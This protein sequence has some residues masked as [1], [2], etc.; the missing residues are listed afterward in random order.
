MKVLLLAGASSIHTIRWANGLSDAGHEVHLV[1]QHQAID[2]FKSNVVIHQFKN[3]GVIGY[4][5][6]AIPVRRLI[7]KIKPD[8]LNAH[9]ASG[10]GTTARLVN[11]HPWVL[12]VWGTD[13]YDFPY[14]S[15][16]H[17]WL[18]RK[19]LRSADRVASTGYNMASQIRSV[20]PELSDIAIT[21]FGVDIDKYGSNRR[22]FQLNKETFVIGTVKTMDQRYGIDILLN[23]FSYLRTLLED[24]SNEVTSVE[25]R[26]VGDGPEIDNFKK[27]AVELGI[28][29]YVT[30]IGRVPHKN[31]PCELS[32]LDIYAALSREESFGVAILEASAAELPVVVS[33]VG[34]LPEVT[35]DGVTGMVVPKEDYKKAALAF[36][37]LIKDHTL[38]R[39]MGESGREHVVKNYDWKKSVSTMVLQYKS[40]IAFNKQGK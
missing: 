22:E 5:F 27:Q 8:I 36:K 19:N 26:I 3:R 28:D 34:G 37:T 11:F 14:K 38:R 6:L 16:L 40:A 35:R 39:K 32:R 4:F 33:D 12:S 2:S 7:K 13:I 17:N 30:F 25:L 20:C 9:Y 15:M 29:N 18:V 1:T 10:Y 24:E 31:V 23:A 21:P